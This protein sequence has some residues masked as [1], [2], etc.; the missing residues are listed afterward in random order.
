MIVMNLV[1]PK[2]G[3][4]SV[5]KFTT[6]VMNLGTLKVAQQSMTN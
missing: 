5:T 4:Q 3:Q 1:T 2:E 6:I